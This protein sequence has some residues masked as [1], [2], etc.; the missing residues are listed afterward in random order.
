MALAAGHS[1]VQHYLNLYEASLCVAADLSVVQNNFEALRV[2]NTEL[3]GYFRDVLGIGKRLAKERD[4]MC[5]EAVGRTPKGVG[6][7]EAATLALAQLQQENRALRQQLGV[8]PATQAEEAAVAAAVQALAQPLS[9]PW[10]GLVVSGLADMEHRLLVAEEAWRK[11]S[12]HSN[13][14]RMP[15]TLDK[16]PADVLRYVLDIRME[17]PGRFDLNGCVVF[18]HQV[19]QV[20]EQQRAV[21]RAG[22]RAGAG[23]SLS[24]SESSLDTL[25]SLQ[26]GATG[27]N[28][29][30]QLIDPVSSPVPVVTPAS[31]GTTASGG[32]TVSRQELRRRLQELALTS[33]SGNASVLEVIE[34]TTSE[35]EAED[36]AS[37]TFGQPFRPTSN[38]SPRLKAALS[39]DDELAECVVR[40]RP[41]AVRR[42]ASVQD[43]LD[44]APGR[45][46]PDLLI[47]TASGDD[48]A[49]VPDTVPAKKRTFLQKIG[50]KRRPAVRVHKMS[51]DD[52]K[53]TYMSR[54]SD[55]PSEPE[56]SVADPSEPDS[57]S[58]GVRVASEE[59]P[60]PV[61]PPPA[62]RLV[63]GHLQHLEAMSVTTSEDS[64]IVARPCSSA[65]KSDSLLSTSSRGFSLRMSLAADGRVSPAASDLS[66]AR[67][68]T[69]IEE[70]R[71]CEDEP[72][73]KAPP[74][75]R[76]KPPPLAELQKR[77]APEA[78]E[79]LVPKGLK[80]RS[81]YL[82]SHN[83]KIGGKV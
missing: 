1:G 21:A 42:C 76:L 51:P 50:F 46:Q 37:S 11:L 60:P 16:P 27:D 61:R 10:K 68:L 67:L 65:S 70:M 14:D 48:A 33:E 71:L 64:G 32:G 36:A 47:G 77:P 34:P 23:R 41:V 74:S 13:S 79:S 40:E 18:R 52:F 45:V 30:S 19:E 9:G 38:S 63:T 39:L 12:F 43:L 73:T 5:R 62:S 31:S 57:A 83:L 44:A 54:L 7:H 3:K 6:A 55:A 28:I 15:V 78:A 58:G 81:N 24:S 29:Y 26:T 2:E 66:T 53:E 35:S 72:D 49:L 22:L 82:N 17:C 20:E 8:E 69:K 4:E 59:P 75:I 80:V 56:E 25:L